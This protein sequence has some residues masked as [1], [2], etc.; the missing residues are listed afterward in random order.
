MSVDGGESGAAAGSSDAVSAAWARLVAVTHRQAAAAANVHSARVM[1]MVHL[2]L[3]V[4][5]DTIGIAR[6]PITV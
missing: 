4:S 6:C 3:S 5:R 2:N 1:A